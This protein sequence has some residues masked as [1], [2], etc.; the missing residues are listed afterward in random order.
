VIRNAVKDLDVLLAITPEDALVL[1]EMK[2]V[3]V[4]SPFDFY[5]G[6]FQYAQLQC[7]LSCALAIDVGLS[8]V[9]S[10]NCPCDVGTQ[11]WTCGE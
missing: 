6:F 2:I 1:E 8:K 5:C 3:K 7:G 10:F 11:Q 9:L 4:G